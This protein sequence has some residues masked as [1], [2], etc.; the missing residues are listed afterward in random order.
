MAGR[1]P[2]FGHHVFQSKL[3]P[4]FSSKANEA[5]FLRSSFQSNFLPFGNLFLTILLIPLYFCW[6]K[7]SSEWLHTTCSYSYDFHNDQTMGY[8]AFTMY[9]ALCKK[10]KKHKNS[11]FSKCC[12][13]DSHKTRENQ[14]E[15]LKKFPNLNL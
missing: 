3:F 11:L 8:Q 1:K 12:L 6:V 4:I 7:N 13:P 15:V 14:F 10:S 9:T 5:F 2:F